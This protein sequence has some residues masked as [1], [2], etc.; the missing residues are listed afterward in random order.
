MSDRSREGLE[1]DSGVLQRILDFVEIMSRRLQ[2]VHMYE[3]ET[4]RHHPPKDMSVLGPIV[5]RLLDT[6]CDWWTIELDDYDE[7][8]D[9]RKLLLGYLQKE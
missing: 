9:T 8:L 4:D 3:R 5:N 6:E 2:E 1:L 7:A